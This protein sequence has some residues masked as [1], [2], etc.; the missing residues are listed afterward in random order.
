MRLARLTGLEMT[1]LDE[2]LVEVRDRI[3]DLEGIL[4]SRPRRMLIICSELHELAE[5]YG[6]DRKTEIA[7]S[8]SGLDV[9]DL[10]AE[11]DMVL[12]VSRQGYVK[13]VPI[14]TYRAQRRG[15]RGMQGMGT[16]EE[17]WVEHLFVASTHDY[18]MV[19]T[20]SGSCYWIKV[21]GIP[22]ARRA[23]RGRSIVNPA[24]HRTG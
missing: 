23:A 1:R 3:R 21:W 14:G 5:K 17:D 9:E 12:T 20:R 10:I 4:E 18:L 15:G 16:K 6:D 11:E 22:E 7:A 8:V 13:R 24:E 2:E 19:F